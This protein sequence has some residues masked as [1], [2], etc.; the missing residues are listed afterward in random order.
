MGRLMESLIWISME[1]SRLGNRASVMGMLRSI[2]KK[3]LELKMQAH[4]F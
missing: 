3:R 1:I 2:K 4:I